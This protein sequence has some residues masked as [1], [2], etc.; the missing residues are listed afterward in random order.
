VRQLDRLF[1]RAAGSARSPIRMLPFAGVFLVG[2]LAGGMIDGDGAGARSP[3]TAA[4]EFATLEATWNLIQEE[5]PLPDEI[6]DAAL[7]Y[8]AAAGMVEALGD[9]G[10]SRFL[11]PEQASA[12]ADMSRGEYTGIGVEIDF[13]RDRPTVIAPFDGSPAWRAGI[14]SGDTIM[15]IDGTETNRIGRE[16][17][18]DM[19][20]GEAGT[21]VTV[22]V[23]SP[24]AP[25]PRE[26]LITR[27]R[28]RIEPVSWRM[29]PGQIAQLRLSE[30]SDGASSKLEAA[31]DEIEQAGAAGLVLDLRDNP[32]GLLHEAVAVSEQFLS[33]GSVIF[34]RQYRDGRI[35][36]VRTV[37]WNGR[38]TDR[39]L[40]VLINGGSSSAA[41]IVG[42]AISR[43]GRAETIGETTY[44]TGTV[45][46][47]FAQGDGSTVLLGTALWLS[48]D[49]ER[50]WKEGVDPDREVELPFDVW[51]S[52]P[53]DDPD[54]TESELAALDDLQLQ[55]AVEALSP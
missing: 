4:P 43:N 21:Q 11:D 33:D 37:G 25:Q 10:H 48:A 29:L 15:S 50:F 28:I 51:P 23:L 20:L 17:V 13:R 12:F 36:E 26:L 1:P 54:V 46:M 14:R 8:G 19:L 53:N 3:L 45:L 27:G 18:A 22:E 6:D 7:I 16:Q 9:D 55:A 52:R 32:G 31:L 34:Q 41:E 39:P 42:G 47:P 38:W 44:G 24:G 5:W 35:E 2:L 49:G 30:F 40:V